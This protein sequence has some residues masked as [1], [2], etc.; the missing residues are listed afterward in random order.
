MKKS[1]TPKLE[2]KKGK[3]KRVAGSFDPLPKGGQYP[4]YEFVDDDYHSFTS[5]EELDGLKKIQEYEFNEVC[6]AYSVMMEKQKNPNFENVLLRKL[7]NIEQSMEKFNLHLAEVTRKT[8]V[9]QLVQHHEK[10]R[11]KIENVRKYCQ[12]ELVHMSHSKYQEILDLIANS[13]NNLNADF[14]HKRRNILKRSERKIL[15]LIDDIYDISNS[16]AREIKH[17]FNET[18]LTLSTHLTN[19]VGTDL[20]LAQHCDKL[21]E[22]FQ[23]TFSDNHECFNY[24]NICKLLSDKLQV[25]QDELEALEEDNLDITLKYHD[26]QQAVSY[27]DNNISIHK[28]IATY[29]R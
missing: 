18:A 26:T 5:S 7:N 13:L 3:S 27:L 12:K 9:D 2:A 1:S 25:T 21:L 29:V 16:S 17:L 23:E 22:K 24:E 10:E 4:E 15:E 6:T 8:Q 14:E 20:N 28:K 11:H 19:V